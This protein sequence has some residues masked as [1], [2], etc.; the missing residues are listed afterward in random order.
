MR[1]VLPDIPLQGGTEEGNFGEASFGNA[2][3]WTQIKPADYAPLGDLRS[4]LPTLLTKHEARAHA[5][6]D[7]K[8]LYADIAKLKRE[9]VKNVVS[10][11]EADRRKARDAQE[12]LLAS[13]KAADQTRPLPEDV[14]AD[15]DDGLQVNER[16][17]AKSLSVEKVRKD[18]K[19]IFLFEAAR[20]LSDEMDVA[21]PQLAS[22]NGLSRPD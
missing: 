13:R 17:L 3:P 12:A 14:N 7:L 1:G 4:I 19:D 9:R 16:S 22:G 6:A 8:N 15:R 10:L 5:D 20:V 21:E 18:A 11:N 2:L